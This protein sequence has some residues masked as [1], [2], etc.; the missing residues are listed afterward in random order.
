MRDG[1]SRNRN[2][3][4]PTRVACA[5]GMALV[6]ALLAGCGKQEA[7]QTQVTVQ[8]EHPE[9]GPIAEHVTADAILQPMAQAA[10]APRISAPVKQF[11]VQRGA[12]VKAGELLAVLDNSDLKAAALDTQGGYESAQ[13]AYA[14]AT[15]AQVPMDVLTAQSDLEQAKA[16]LSLDQSIVKSRTQLFAEGAI[17]GRD[18]DTAKAQLVQAQAAY[19]AANK[20]MQAVESV[21]RQ[22]SLDAAQGQLK[23]A[24][25][26]YEGAEAQVNFS[27]I[28]SPI[29]G[30]VTDRPLFAGETAAAGSPLITVMDT[31]SLIAKTHVAQSMAQ[32]LKLGSQAQVTVPGIDTPV[33]ATVSMIS[34]AL[35]PGSTTVEIWLKLN[36]RS[37]A[38]KVG[39]PVKL[40]I[41]G[42]TVPKALTIPLSAVLTADNGAKSVMVVASDG[43][44]Q[45]R[46]VKLGITNGEDVQ[47]LS[48]LTPQDQVITVGSY[49]MDAG[50]KV[51]VGP[52]AAD[53][54][55]AGA[56]GGGK[57]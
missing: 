55:D 11:Y 43:T 39:T 45:P 37:G 52:A 10:L 32:Q 41:T 56:Q 36:N 29:N 15:K 49:G 48:G 51:K 47:V 21:T 53:E 17:P 19:D 6:I 20:H 13:A 4:T 50:T 1:E 2:R 16:N 24:Q 25:G 7:P 33:P 3:R 31:S 35:D 23:S 30:V 38:L 57:D 27:E 46:P 12:H 8:A 5:A 28:R 44:A 18:L 54:G 42:H 14:T 22:A 9:T 40:N 34:P 26:K